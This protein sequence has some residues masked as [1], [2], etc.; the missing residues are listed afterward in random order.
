MM[1]SFDRASKAHPQVVQFLIEYSVNDDVAFLGRQVRV[2]RIVLCPNVGDVVFA[3]LVK[4]PVK[5]SS[6]EL[7]SSL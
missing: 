2:L 6:T 4:V 7:F 3:N 1:C 5:F